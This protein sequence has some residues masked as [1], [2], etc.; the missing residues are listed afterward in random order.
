MFLTAARSKAKIGHFFREGV[1]ILQADRGDL[2]ALI[3]L[4]IA[5]G[6]LPKDA[7]A[8]V[9]AGYG[10]G[11]TCAACDLSTTTEDVEYE[12]D[13]ADGRS[14]AIVARRHPRPMT[15]PPPKGGP[16]R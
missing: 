2:T 3:R 9:F 6:V 1:P 8:K 14:S 15:D 13:M 7:P 11:K 5:T 12:V 4:R 16:A 10:T